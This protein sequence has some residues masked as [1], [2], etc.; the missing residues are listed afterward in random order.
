MKAARSFLLV[1][2]LL[3]VACSEE[4]AT[5]QVHLRCPANPPAGTL[6]L[7]G[8]TVDIQTA[9]RKQTLTF[10]T[11]SANEPLQLKLRRADGVQAE[12]TAAYGEEL[13]RDRH[14]FHAIFE[15]LTEPPYVRAARL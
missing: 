11:H 1:L 12:A 3:L 10:D 4:P 2:C 8:E 9:C 14:G 5:L 15:L 13:Q 6:V 7:N